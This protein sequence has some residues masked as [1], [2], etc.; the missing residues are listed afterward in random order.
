MGL[1]RS[2]CKLFEFWNISRYI[3]SLQNNDHWFFANSLNFSFTNLLFYESHMEY[4]Y[5]Y[6]RWREKEIISESKRLQGLC[7]LTPEET[8]LVLQALGFEKNTLIYIA[9]GETYGGNRRLAALRA[10]FPRLVSYYYTLLLVIGRIWDPLL[11]QLITYIGL[12]ATKF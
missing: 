10:S 5:A 4:R 6:P 9:S 1:L 8:S 3:N 12:M 11:L 7:P 2:A